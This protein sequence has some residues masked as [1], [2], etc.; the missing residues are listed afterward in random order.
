MKLIRARE[1]QPKAQIKNGL[2]VEVWKYHAEQYKAQDLDNWDFTKEPHMSGFASDLVKKNTLDIPSNDSIRKWLTKNFKYSVMDG[3]YFLMKLQGTLIAPM[4][5]IYEFSLTSDDGSFL[6]LGKKALGPNKAFVQNGGLHGMKKK[7]NTI[8]LYKGQPLDYTVTF[9]GN[10]GGN[11]LQFK[12][13]D[14][15]K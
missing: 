5:G 9:Y 3:A 8:R 1:R 6:Y 15:K 2:A 4:D 10:G 11:G 7:T 12:I 13:L 14:P